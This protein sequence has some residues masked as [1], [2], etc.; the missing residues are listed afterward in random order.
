MKK[1]AF[2]LIA[3][4]SILITSMGAMAQGGASPYLNSTHTYT[5]T[6]Q[7]NA[8]SA[9]W[10]IADNAG[11]ALAT[12]PTFTASKVGTTA[13]MV[14]TW[15][16]SWASVADYKVWFTETGTCSTKRE[17]PVTVV[18][19]SFYL[20]M[21]AD[22]TECHDLSGQILGVDAVGNTTVLFTANLNKAAAWSI[23]SWKFDFAVNVA[24]GYT[25]Q[26]VKLNGGSDL[27]NT[28]SYS[29]QSVAG[30]LSSATI[31]VVINGHVETGATVT[32]N[33]SN[34]KAIKGTTTTPDNGTGGGADRTQVLTV[35]ALP[36]TSLI[37]AD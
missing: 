2:Y 6:M 15:A 35:N 31:E 24:T 37:I 23:D 8:N 18:A 5:V 36:A 7:N 20:T 11:V 28:G 19:N 21:N 22:G 25:L 13:T 30:T 14:I 17:L 26:T 16:E 9:A 33:L 27:G 10:V 4:V 12:Q 1:T 3:L 34:G 29:N 32:V